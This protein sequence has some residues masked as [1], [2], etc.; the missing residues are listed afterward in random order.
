VA[1]KQAAFVNRVSQTRACM[2]CHACHHIEILMCACLR[3]MHAPHLAHTPRKTRLQACCF[4]NSNKD[5][6]DAMF[7]AAQTNGMLGQGSS[8]MAGQ[9]G[10]SDG[11]QVLMVIS[12]P[13]QLG[14]E[15]GPTWEGVPIY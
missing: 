10:F 2:Q 11:G 8:D 15:D 1:T 7:L 12:L 9:N 5:C 6:C 3:R 13:G 4:E 14:S